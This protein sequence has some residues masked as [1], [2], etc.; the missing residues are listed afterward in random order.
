MTY[1]LI[2]A[3]GFF[4]AVLRYLITAWLQA[5]KGGGYPFG[6]FSVNMVGSLLIGLLIGTAANETWQLLL[7][8]GLAGALTTYSTMNMETV[9]L[10]LDRRGAVAALYLVLSYIAG[11]LLA[12]IGAG[13][14]HLFF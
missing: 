3:G 9:L 10:F 8:T 2:A 4:G 11:P 7:G 5:G 6:T 13:V 1:A 14:G 12:F